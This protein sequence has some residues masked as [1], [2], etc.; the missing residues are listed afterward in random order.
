MELWDRLPFDDHLLAGHRRLLERPI[1][2]AE[3]RRGFYTVTAE[4]RAVY[5]SQRDHGLSLP[6]AQAE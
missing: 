2:S 4:D 3:E 5:N 6:Y 1:H